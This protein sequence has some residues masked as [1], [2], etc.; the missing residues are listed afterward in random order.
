MALRAKE[1]LQV[2]TLE[3]VADR[4]YY[5]GQHI[6]ACL[7]DGT[8]PYIPKANTSANSRLGLYGKR[9]FSYDADHDCYWCPAGQALNF[10]FQTTEEG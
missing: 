1:V 9:D 4:G 2:E 3:V 7:E 6:K 10:R 5:D 8:T